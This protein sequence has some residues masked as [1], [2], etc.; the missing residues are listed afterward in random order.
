MDLHGDSYTVHTTE[1]MAEFQEPE[2]STMFIEPF[3]IPAWPN[4]LLG[5]LP[6]GIVPTTQT[7][8]SL[9][10][11]QTCTGRVVLDSLREEFLLANSEHHYWLE[12]PTGYVRSRRDPSIL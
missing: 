11:A 5:I 10:T 12:T 7:Q 1:C 2:L 8:Y 3:M 9:T 4:M 6:T